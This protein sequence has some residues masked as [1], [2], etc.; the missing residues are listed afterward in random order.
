MRLSLGPLLYYWPRATVLEFYEKMA[1]SPVSAIYLGEIVC[2][3][4][5]E[6]RRPDWLDLGRDLASAGK[7]VVL[8][9][10]V[11]IESE[12][13]LKAMRR[14][15]DNGVFTVEAN[16]MGAVRLLT[17]KSPFVAGP[18][19]NVYNAQTLALLAG[20]GAKRWVP[21]VEMPGAMLAALLR[22][23]PAG[24]ET[25]LFGYGRLPLAHSARCFTARRDNRPK[26]DCG[27]TCL[28]HPDGMPLE[29]QEGEP[30]LAVNGV[31]TQSALVHGLTRELEDATA[32]NIDW[33]RISPQ[34]RHTPHI[35]KLY[36]ARLEGDV[37]ADEIYGELEGL[38]P[39]SL[40]NGYWY[41]EA[42]RHRVGVTT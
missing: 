32:M 9:T 10:P 33:L 16:D 24:I 30:F 38:A 28:R 29:T 21:P 34:S 19:L 35:A 2:S 27:F 36:A 1:G 3:R 13:D 14:I 42:G 5:H 37:T 7:E 22:E 39:A 23:A 4:R 17:G 11:L 20:L 25:E 26:D 40:C 8:S 15:A 6:M 41:G 12:S 18:H 31:Q